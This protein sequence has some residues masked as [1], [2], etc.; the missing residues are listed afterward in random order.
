MAT[1]SGRAHVE[2]KPTLPKNSLREKLDKRLL[3]LESQALSLEEQAVYAEKEA[4]LRKRMQ[5]AQARI[6]ANQ[7]QS[8]IDL[9]SL[10]GLW[11]RVPTPLKVLLVL[12]VLMVVLVFLGRSCSGG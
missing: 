2:K 9:S 8:A 1:K 3:E 11:G 5:D 6:K 10:L 7:P 4:Q 12:L